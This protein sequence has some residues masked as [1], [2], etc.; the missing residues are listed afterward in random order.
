MNT[1]NDKPLV[2]LHGEI[3]TPP[4][5][6]AAGLE[7]GFLLRRLQQGENLSLP[8]SR[9]MPAVGLNCHEL[10]II[11]RDSSWRLIYR[12]DPDAIILL[13]VF[14]K[15]TR[16]TPPMVSEAPRSKLAGIFDSKET[17][18]KSDENRLEA[19]SLTPQQ[20]A[21]N[22]LA[23]LFN[24]VNKGSSAT[25]WTNFKG[26]WYEHSREKPIARKRLASWLRTGF[27]RTDRR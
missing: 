8:H 14:E 21:E 19:R 15:K 4:F 12:A 22:A 20:A 7:V 25:T 27:S 2:W 9:P 5:S 11:D 23:I 17:R 13:D 24:D 6:P 1:S 18:R 3:R 16:A 26:A 10:R